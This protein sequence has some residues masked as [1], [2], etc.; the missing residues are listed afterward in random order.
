VYR[1]QFDGVVDPASAQVRQAVVVLARAS[2]C[3]KWLIGKVVEVILSW[4]IWDNDSYVQVG[5][6]PPEYRRG[7]LDMCH[8]VH[9]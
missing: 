7:G 9:V 8:Q 5:D 3:W 6:N 4:I 1:G 2:G